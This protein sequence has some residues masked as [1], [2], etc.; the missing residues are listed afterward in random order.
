[1]MA[2]YAFRTA[3][4]NVHVLVGGTISEEPVSEVDLVSEDTSEVG[5][6]E[7]V[8]HPVPIPGRSYEKWL[9]LKIT[10]PPMVRVF[11][12]RF[13]FEGTVDV[14]THL[15]FGVTEE[16]RAAVNTESDIA[17]HEIT[18]SDED[19]RVMWHEQFI[20]VADFY[21]VVDGRNVLMGPDDPNLPTTNALV[22]QLVVDAGATEGEFG[23]SGAEKAGPLYPDDPGLPV[24]T[25]P[26][27]GVT[28]PTLYYQ[29]SE[30]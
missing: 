5:M 20:E 6:L 7:R 28:M 26:P 4:V 19:S 25:W 23:L 21:K 16:R 8:Y 15:L 2:D 12:F 29:Y 17:V 18:L 9:V 11:A 24:P 3:T 10:T 1:M 30:I 27:V 22:L 13:W 14:N